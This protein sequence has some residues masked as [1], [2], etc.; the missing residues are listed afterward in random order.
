MNDLD[1][2]RSVA[3]VIHDEVIEV[4]LGELLEGAA[5]DFSARARG[6]A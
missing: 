1:G 6:A 4:F 2:K 3:A 5:A